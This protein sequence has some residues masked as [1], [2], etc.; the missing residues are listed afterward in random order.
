M[1]EGIKKFCPSQRF[2][3][4]I[5]GGQFATNFSKN[6]DL[7][8]FLLKFCSC[9]PLKTPGYTAAQAKSHAIL[10]APPMMAYL[11]TD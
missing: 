10:C 1:R 11:I 7:S 6:T 5:K 8:A 2:F 3:L 4:M 9:P